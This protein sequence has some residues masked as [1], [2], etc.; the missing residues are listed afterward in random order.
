MAAAI[1]LREDFDAKAL[2]ALAKRTKDGPQARRLLALAAIYDGATRGEAAK[3]GNV[4]LQIVR[5]WVLRF[6]A[7]GLPAIM[8]SAASRRARARPAAAMRSIL[9]GAGKTIRRSRSCCS[10][11]GMIAEPLSDDIASFVAR[12]SKSR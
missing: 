2:R 1:G 5:D 6:N 10:N 7:S 4:T 11:A 3:I 12:S 9:A 8:A